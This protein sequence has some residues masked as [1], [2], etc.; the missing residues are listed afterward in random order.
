MEGGVPDQHPQRMADQRALG[1][2]VVPRADVALVDLVLGLGRARDDRELVDQSLALV[3][4]FALHIAVAQQPA[5]VEGLHIAAQSLVQ[6]HVVGVLIGQLVAE[7][8]M[9][10]LVL[11]QPV[12]AAPVDLVAVAIG[13]DGLVLHAQ[14]RG[15]DHAHLLV[16]EGEGADISLEE[17]QHLWKLGEQGLDLVGRV[18]LQMPVVHRDRIAEPAF[19]L[20]ADL[21]VGADIQ[22]DGVGVGALRRPV[23]G[24]PA[25]AVVDLAQEPSVGRRRQGRG[26]GDVQVDP[27]R[28][29]VR[30]VDTG[31]E[32]VA[33]LALD[34][35]GDPGL[36]RWGRGPDEAAV[37]GGAG[38]DAGPAGVGDAQGDALTGGQGAGQLDRQTAF[39]IGPAVGGDLD[40][41]DL[42]GGDGQQGVQFDLQPVQRGRGGEVQNRDGVDGPVLGQD[43]DRQVGLVEPHRL[44]FRR[45][46]L[47]GGEG[48]GGRLARRRGRRGGRGAGGQSQGGRREGQGARNCHGIPSEYGRSLALGRGGGKEKGRR[49]R[50]PFPETDAAVADQAAAACSASLART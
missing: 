43:P 9:G 2:D 27:A 29:A 21:L 39:G 4:Q 22:G 28:L 8:F 34:G 3:G 50:R 15:L 13:V 18:R 41:V 10:E 14:V 46:G 36:A 32:D 19:V 45:Q 20:A 6:P 49:R 5:G 38:R 48:E 30:A 31:P 35:G 16:A 7:P 25:V 47:V 11:K 24:G 1:I 23:P 37:P 12:I 33:A 44:L 40:P 26:D 17:V 42:D